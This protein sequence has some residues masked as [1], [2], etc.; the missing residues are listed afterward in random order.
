MTT[1]TRDKSLVQR[2]LS[3][4]AA[5]G[6]IAGALIYLIA[7]TGTLVVVLEQWQR[8]EQ[9]DIAESAGLTP[10][11]AQA[12]IPNV[13]A[14]EA[15]MTPTA[16]LYIRMPNAA[17]PRPVVTTD[18]K[19]W[20]IDGE[21]RIAGREGHSWTEMVAALH[22]NLTLPVIWGMILV[23]AL[24]VALAALLVTGVVAHPKIFKDAFRL[25]ARAEPQL[26]RTDW[27]NRLGV[28]TLPFTLM[29]T[30]TGAFIG[31]SYTSVGTLAQ[32]YT[33]G[34]MDP[35]YATIF[36]AEPEHDP[37]PAPMANIARAMETVAARFPDAEPTYIVVHDPMTQGQFV[38][39]IAEHPRQLIYGEVYSFDGA[40][41]YLGKVGLS[42]GALGRQAA[43][44][45]Y[46]LHFG[47][48]AGLPV[49]LAYIAFGI[50]LCV[51]TATGTTMWLRKR[52]RKGHDIARMAAAWA[53]TVWGIP[54]VLVLVA[55][56]R[57]AGGPDMPVVAAFWGLLGAGLIAAAAWPALFSDAAMRRVLGIAMI[58]GALLH[59]VWFGGG[60]PG[61]VAMNLA[62]LATGA[63]IWRP[64]LRTAGVAAPRT[65][66]PE[67]A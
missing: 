52:R 15:D 40:G 25:R 45:T 43:A 65:G 61:V 64:G 56:L 3:G 6:L 66:R 22:Y 29:V 28:W 33:G 1:A 16:H 20:Y 38:Q 67:T 51:I 41:S 58:A 63:V 49:Q 46:N 48:Y 2:A 10:Q 4:H 44:S 47:N 19:A 21:G 37:A 59:L 32:S 31:L 17:L 12:S 39:V 13:R 8:W 34:A 27:H 36:G 5:I 55:A 53:M 7:V 26:A 23:G 54:L 11:A 24:G 60:A 50:A 9:P 62:I 35:V 18:N 30:L 14:Q 57:F 42:D